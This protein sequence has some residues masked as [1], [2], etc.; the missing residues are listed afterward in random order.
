MRLDDRLRERM[1]WDGRA[2]LADFLADWDRSTAD[3]DFT[4]GAGDW[5]HQAAARL[6]GFLVERVDAPGPIA[7]VSHGGITVD[8]LRTLLGDAAVPAG[9]I[10]RGLPP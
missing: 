1:N 5:S 3:R 6:R 10:R 8:L 9:L 7:V 4:S 2:P